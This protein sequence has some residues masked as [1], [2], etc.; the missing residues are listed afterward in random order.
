[1]TARILLPTDYSP[2]SLRAYRVALS[3]AAER[4]APLDVVHA[5]SAPFFGPAYD[6]SAAPGTHESLFTLIREQAESEMKTF[7]GS[8]EVPEGV[9]LTSRVV[10]GEPVH[11]VLEIEKE[12]PT[13][14]VVVGSHGRKG[15]AYLLLGSVAARMVQLAEAPVLVVPAHDEGPP[16]ERLEPK[17]IVVGVD[18][19]DATQSTIRQAVAFAQRYGA[20]VEL[21]HVIAPPTMIID[22]LT[23][24]DQVADDHRQSIEKDLRVLADHVQVPEGVTLTRRVEFGVPAD[25]IVG[26]AGDA[27]LVVMGTHGRTGLS[28]LVL[29]SV[30]EKVSRTSPCPVLTVKSPK[31]D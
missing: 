11:A 12:A 4:G 25:V 3:L 29:G 8:V 30:A 22:D 31:S 28:R 27:Q 16:V 17:R 13:E 5:W 7:L 23:L 6:G 19:S 2:G 26:A 10:S 1:M 18:F 15:A 9:A 20:T 21:L 24:W 14:L